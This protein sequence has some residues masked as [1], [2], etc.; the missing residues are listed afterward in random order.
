MRK[1]LAALAAVVLLAAPLGAHAKFVTVASSDFD[2]SED[3]IYEATAKGFRFTSNCHLHTGVAPVAIS[4]DN[5][6]CYEGGVYNPNFIGPSEYQVGPGVYV[7]A[8]VYVDRYGEQFSLESLTFGWIMKEGTQL[9][10]SDGRSMTLGPYFIEDTTQTRTFDIGWND[11]TSF[12]LVPGIVGS[13]SDD[14][15]RVMTMQVPEPST[16]GLL[17]LG[18]LAIAVRRRAVR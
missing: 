15:P 4:T 5:S 9:I 8:V 17:A 3:F 13:W 11:I 10:A 6:G 7:P 18:L 12:M 2:A 16:L 1:G 14:M